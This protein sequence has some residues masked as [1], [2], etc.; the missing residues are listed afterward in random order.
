M[1]EKKEP[2]Q[3]MK[4][5]HQLV[6]LNADMMRKAFADPDMEMIVLAQLNAQYA[7]AALYAMACGNREDAAAF[8]ELMDVGTSLALQ[9]L[10]STMAPGN[11]SPGG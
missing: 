3:A 10:L 5:T 9:N 1:S 11:D 6:L 4:R 8:L 2:S 7:G